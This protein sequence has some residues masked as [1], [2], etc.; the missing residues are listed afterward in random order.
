MKANEFLKELES[1]CNEELKCSFRLKF[2]ITCTIDR[3][4]NE[5][6]LLRSNIKNVLSGFSTYDPKHKKAINLKRGSTLN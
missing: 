5:N 2:Q 6:Q 1:H 4:I 3:L